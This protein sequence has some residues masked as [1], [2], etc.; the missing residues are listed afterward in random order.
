MFVP[1]TKIFNSS[2]SFFERPVLHGENSFKQCSHSFKE[3]ADIP[4]ITLITCE[5]HSHPTIQHKEYSQILHPPPPPPMFSSTYEHLAIYSV[6]FIKALNMI[7]HP[8]FFAEN[9]TKN[10][11]FSIFSFFVLTRLPCEISTKYINL[12]I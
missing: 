12:C 3:C 11:W 7:T 10:T 2:L 1:A 8:Y 4:F 5:R 6:N 9:A